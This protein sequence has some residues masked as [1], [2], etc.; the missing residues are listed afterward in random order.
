MAVGHD[1]GH[2]HGHLSHSAGRAGDRRRLWLALA[3]SV[4]VMA[5]EL[6][7]AWIA[8]SLALFGDAGHVATDAASVVL[9]LGASAMAARPAGPRSTFGYHRAEILAAAINAL[10][11]LGVC[12][13]LVYF[14]IH[15]LASPSAV[16]AGPMIAFALIGLVANVAAVSVLGRGSGSLNLKAAA[17]EATSDAVGSLLAVVAGIVIAL[18]GWDR[19]DPIASLL[20]AAI[21]LPRSILLLKEAAAVLLEVAPA[22]LSLDDVRSELLAVDSVTAVPD[23]HAWTITSGLASL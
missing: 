7:G 14:G 8:G 23:H 20:I 21:I 1:H 15:R 6:A 13:F 2:E 11:L 3:I 16:E 4:V 12:T 17:L 19:A 5:V 9:A 10:V 22:G 18:S